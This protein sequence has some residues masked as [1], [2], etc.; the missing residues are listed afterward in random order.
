MSLSQICR[1]RR[2]MI[3]TPTAALLIVALLVSGC[4]AGSVSTEQKSLNLPSSTATVQVTPLYDEGTVVSLYERCIPA[5]VQVESETTISSKLLG[6]FGLDIPNMR[7]QGSGF[8]IDTE[9]HILTNN[10][11]VD[12]ASTVKVVLSDGTELQGKV[13]GVDRNNDVA[14]LQIDASRAPNMAYLALADSSKVKPG[15][16]ALALGSPYGL[17][18]S[19][20]IGIISGTGRSIPNS[21]SR[22]ITDI[23]QT[24]AAINP[25]N[26]GGPLLN[27]QGEVI[28][29]NT[30]IEASANGVG[31]AIPINT[32]RQALPELLKGST[33][34]TP[35]LG[36]EGMP[37][38]RDLADKLDLKATK[39][40]YVVGVMTGSPAD[41]A[42][43]VESGRNEQNE[44]AAGGD[45][46]MAVDETAVA[47]V[48]DI[49]SYFNG[50]KPGD[51]VTLS[52]QR[53]D[54]QISA[55]VE[56]AEWPDRLPG[57]YEFD[58]GSG[59]DWMPAPDSEQFEFKFGP[60]EFR[61][62]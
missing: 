18:G 14:L 23:I 19:I 58:Q 36:I 49:L 57:Y 24:D 1:G 27:S 8:I 4:S 10:H 34:R 39:G 7:G 9:G 61:S 53:G 12:K 46:I 31:F 17:Q 33:I 45:I 32:A 62:K 59:Q 55:P 3:A 25:G 2:S 5:V 26:S 16:M 13:I 41:K 30:A 47:K 38:S 44:P 22:N 28:G 21:N 43:L 51:K 50:K 37:V 40:V 54:Q 60:F 20:T 29:I 42:G 48:D 56:L 52:I 15:Q 6:P 11:V 35:W